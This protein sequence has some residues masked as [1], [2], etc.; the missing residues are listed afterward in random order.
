[1]APATTDDALLDGRV[2]L[3]Q[4]ADGY[5]VAIDP[6][7][8]AAAVPARAGDTVLELGSGV[9]AAS[10]CLAR[11]VADCRLTGLEIDGSAVALA[12]DNAA[13]NFVD[14]R[15][16][17]VAGDLRIPPA[18]ITAGAFDHVIANPPHLTV[19]AADTPAHAGK[20]RANIE[21]AAELSHWLDAMLRLVRP[22]GRVTLIHRADRLADVLAG[23]RGRAGAIVVFPLWPGG[24][25]PA[26]RV[27]ITTRRGVATP[28]RL[29]AGLVLHGSDGQYTTAAQSVLRDGG[30][31]DLT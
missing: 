7:L 8:L 19:A 6:V 31:L 18:W 28:L 27:I 20:T 16:V 25:Q 24:N 2:A 21:G 10:L 9:G 11:R 17:F 23:L 26:K 12:N 5:R 30:A 1:M 22:K 13:R 4:P 15:V 29:S 3:R 14:D